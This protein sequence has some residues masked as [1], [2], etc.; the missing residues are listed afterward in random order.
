MK[1]TSFVAVGLGLVAGGLTYADTAPLQSLS[2]VDIAPDASS[3]APLLKT[4]ERIYIVAS[5]S[6]S[7]SSSSFA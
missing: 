1:Q 2:T 3:E 7:S 5:A 4:E 6:S